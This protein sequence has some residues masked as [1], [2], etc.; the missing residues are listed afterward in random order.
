MY[1]APVSEIA[2]ALKHVA[3]LKAALDA[4]RLG[5][6]SEDLVDAILAEAGRYATDVVA[7]LGPSATSRARA[8]WMARW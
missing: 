6:L 5:D 3:G 4:G 7:P 2:F 1:K 8:L